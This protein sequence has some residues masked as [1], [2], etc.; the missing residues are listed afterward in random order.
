[1][2]ELFISAFRSGEIT[3]LL[4]NPETAW[5]CCASGL[6]DGLFPHRVEPLTSSLNSLPFISML[7]DGSK[8]SGAAAAP[9]FPPLVGDLT[10]RL[11][12]DTLGCACITVSGLAAGVG[13][14]AGEPRF[15]FRFVVTAGALAV[16][17]PW[18]PEDAPWRIEFFI[19]AFVLSDMRPSRY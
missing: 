2:I 15:K 19:A 18:E 1:M 16:A 17:A 8:G 7:C 3:P 4:Y 5:S 14:L 11:S 10:A 13:F 12:G 6:E 9:P